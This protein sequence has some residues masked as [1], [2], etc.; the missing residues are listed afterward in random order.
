MVGKPTTITNG[1]NNPIFVSKS[2][3]S[4]AHTDVSLTPSLGGKMHAWGK[5]RCILLAQTIFSLGCIT[6]AGPWLQMP[7]NISTTF[8]LKKMKG[9]I[10]KTERVYR[11]LTMGTVNSPA[12]ACRLGNSEVRKLRHEHALFH[13]VISENSWGNNLNGEGYT[14]SIGHGQV[15]LNQEGVPAALIFSM[16]DD[17]MVHAATKEQAMRAFSVFMDHIVNLGFICQSIKTSPPAQQQN[18]ME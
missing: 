10:H 18:I 14:E 12:I 17:F 5:T 3:T 13:G 9:S 16:V 1:Y 11:G 2:H 7:P 15:E 8:R 6:E 4:Q